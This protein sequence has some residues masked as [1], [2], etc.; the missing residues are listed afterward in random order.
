MTAPA[1][2]A[3]NWPRLERWVADQGHELDTSDV[4]QLSGGA[5]NLN[6]LVVLNGRRA[7][8]RRPP[9]G[10]L[11]A[12]A[13][14]MAREWRVLSGLNTGFPL[15]PEAL[16]FGADPEVIGV[17]FQL[18]EFRDGVSVG[19]ELPTG[20]PEDAP[21][22]LTAALIESM[23]ALH[24]LD[25]AAVGLGDLGRPDGFL[26]R[27]LD[28]WM[29]RA[30]A[31]WPDGLPPVVDRLYGLLA[32][33][34]P[35]P[36]EARLL[37]LD[38][39]LDNLLI[40]EVTLG[41]RALVDWELATRGCPL[42][43]LA[44]L[45]SYWI[46]PTDPP[47]LHALSQVPSL[48]PGFGTRQELAER[49]FAVSGAPSRSLIWHVGCAR[50]RLGVAWMQLYRLWQRGALVGERY[51]AFPAVAHAV[52]AFAETQIREGKT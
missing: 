7:V 46:E 5:A 2:F 23:A 22:R 41:P 38:F 44:V 9:A 42:F 43:D 15:A 17:Q 12:G 33:E 14:D 13:G 34:I 10:G 6:Y 39:K 4:I 29:R 1:V 37:H 48:A 16:L 49:Y 40:D 47:E 11:A 50:L 31:V 20:L 21:Q 27:Q 45:L 52:L 36:R 19:G 24:N 32:R 35:P 3:Q 51:A 30:R 26:D 8:L 18:I 25:P 28:G